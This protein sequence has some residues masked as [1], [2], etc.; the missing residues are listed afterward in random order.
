M[1]QNSIHIKTE[2]LQLSRFQAE[3]APALAAYRHLPEVARF[4]GWEDFPLT[5]AEELIASLGEASPW[6][7]DS[8]YQI[9][10][11]LGAEATLIGDIGYRRRTSGPSYELEIGYS[12]DPKFQKQGFMRE[13]LK[14]FIEWAEKQLFARRILA[15]LD[16]RNEDSARLLLALGFERQAHFRQSVWFK[17]AWADDDVYVYFS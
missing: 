4:Q 15:S 2:R 9:A 7:L 8:W 12:L 17:G 6:Q 10:L 14:A 3:D 5:R 11:R 13:A 16:P 1:T